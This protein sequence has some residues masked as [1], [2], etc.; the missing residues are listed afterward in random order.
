[1]AQALVAA[2]G[3]TARLVA[4]ALALDERLVFG[5]TWRAPARPLEGTRGP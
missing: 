5:R 2:L 3:E 4:A 1:V